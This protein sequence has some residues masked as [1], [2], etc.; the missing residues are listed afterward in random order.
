MTHSKETTA[1]VSALNDCIHFFFLSRIKM[2]EHG[3]TIPV[4]EFAQNIIF[5]QNFP[6]T[7]IYFVSHY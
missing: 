6:L 3:E 1:S 5:Q 7:A 2:K 4:G